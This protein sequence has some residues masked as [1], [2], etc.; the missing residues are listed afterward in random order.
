M[1]SWNNDS[2]LFELIRSHLFT[3]VVGDIMDQLHLR[4]QFL[5]P[6][7]QPI[8][9]EWILVG[10][11]MP[12]LVEDLTERN[13]FLHEEKPFGLMLEALDDLKKNEVYFA[14]GGSPAFALWGELMSTRA[15]KLGAAG[16]VLNGYHRDTSGIL[17]LGFPT[18]SYGAYAQD[19]APRGTVLDFRLPITL[20]SV[21]VV[22][23]D[24][25]FGDRDGVCVIPQKSESEIIHASLDKV[26][27]E[28]LVRKAIADGMS[29]VNAFE[30][31]GIM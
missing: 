6:Q 11:A 21:T 3:A 31:Y 17:D 14:S 12:V 29:A 13:M 1:P 5:P 16:A 15:I 18:F 23:G 7:I 9:P 2:E 4:N 25:I 10:R 28:Q 8:V 20:G 24:I 26:N 19:Q 27:G 30:K 22:P